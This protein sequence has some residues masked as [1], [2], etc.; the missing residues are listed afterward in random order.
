M[1]PAVIGAGP[2]R[3]TSKRRIY[4]YKL[5]AEKSREWEVFAL[6]VRPSAQ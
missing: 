1:I 6:Y 5:T 4:L 3:T 2:I